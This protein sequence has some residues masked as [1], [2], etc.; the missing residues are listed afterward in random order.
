[1]AKMRWTSGIAT[2]VLIVAATAT[3]R[4][5]MPASDGR[6]RVSVSGA[7]ANLFRIEDRS[8]GKKFNVGA[9]AAVKLTNRLWAD[10]EINRFIG[11]EPEPAPCGLVNVECTGGGRTAYDS[12]TAGSLGLTYRFGSDGV[13]ATVSGGLGF[14]RADGFGTITFGNTGQQVEMAISDDGW[15][16]TVG[17]GLSIPVGSRWAL[18]PTMRI[19][20]ADAP[21]LTVVRAGVALT[22]GF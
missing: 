2:L 20:G 7:F 11:L 4:A 15:G 22:R 12:A 5:Q 13:R 8:F 18:E 16:P 17:I 19:Y 3:T 14:V 1:M 10:V 21:N 9:G 6:F